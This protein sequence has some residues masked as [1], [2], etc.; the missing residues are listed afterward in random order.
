MKIDLCIW[1]DVKQGITGHFYPICL[2]GHKAT[3]RCHSP[4]NCPDYY[5]SLDKPLAELREVLE[6]KE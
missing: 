6:G 5:W 1:Y 4:N 2:K 3:L